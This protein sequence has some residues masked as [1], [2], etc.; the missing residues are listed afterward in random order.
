M[1]VHI[2]GNNDTN[3]SHYHITP[4]HDYSFTCPHGKHTVRIPRDPYSIK[5]RVSYYN[6]SVVDEKN[7]GIDDIPS[8]AIKYF[9]EPP[10]LKLLP[11]DPLIPIEEGFPPHLHP[12]IA[13]PATDITDS[14][15]TA[16]WI[17]SPENTETTLGYYLDVA[18][19][20]AFTT[21]VTGYRN[22]DVGNGLEWTITGLTFSTNYY[23]KLRAYNITLLSGDSNIITVTTG[24]EVPHLDPPVALPATGVSYTHIDAFTANWET[25]TDATGY[26]LYVSVVEDFS[27]YEQYHIPG[28][29]VDSYNLSG[30]EALDNYWYKLTA[31]NATLIS[32]FS[33][34]I[35]VTTT[36]VVT[37]YG[38]LY[39]WYAINGVLLPVSQCAVFFNDSS[40]PTKVY[41]YEP[42]TGSLT[43]RTTLDFPSPDITS[44]L[45]K[46][47]SLGYNSGSIGKF[48]EYDI[49]LDPFT[50]NFNRDII[51]GFADYPGSG[52][53]MK[54]DHTL[55]GSS[56]IGPSWDVE[57]IF[58]YDISN[59][60]VIKTQ[61]FSLNGRFVTGDIIYNSITDTYIIATNTLNNEYITE[62]ASDGTII[63]DI[64]ISLLDTP[65]VVYGLFCYDDFVFAVATDQTDSFIYKITT[66]D[67]SGIELVQTIEGKVVYGASQNLSCISANLPTNKDVY[68]A[69]YNWYAASKN[70]G[71]GVGSI[72]PTG[73]HVPTFDEWLV[74]LEYLGENSA[75]HLK[76][77]GF[78]HWNPPNT[79]ADNSSG[80]TALGSGERFSN[81]IYM[82]IGYGEFLWCVTLHAD[83]T[84][85]S[86]ILYST[87]NEG[88][89]TYNFTKVYGHSIR[90]LANFTTKTHGQTGTVTDVDG[91]VYST[92]C[93][94]SQEWMAENLKTEHFN[95]GD[96][97]PMGGTD[98]TFFTG[99]EWA[100]LTDAGM[101]YYDNSH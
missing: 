77:V 54:D 87:G 46:I 52:L 95:N 15:F 8:R 38:A 76:E 23:Y 80:F 11:C 12:P 27:V 33:N 61:L 86:L 48:V 70:G 29:S 45:T 51:I 83:G 41:S 16:N 98:P 22:V 91:N 93:I 13:L 43:Y 94:G 82:S 6:T 7:P 88:S 5:G 85:Y 21:Y 17:P 56:T 84:C 89:I 73:W 49:T 18:T 2:R 63:T 47:W 65:R 59:S 53:S 78:T 39:N 79:G 55:I 60:P 68:G 19:D 50:I 37:G 1:A 31:Y 20:Y 14:A 69:L 40:D 30:L 10:V 90:C 62:Y 100:A 34:T 25:I 101:C 97:I 4:I 71:T 35:H 44:S 75:G 81:G 92:I 66:N 58:L 9:S 24:V 99:E 42:T 3:T 28:Q 96:D 64:D 26:Y 57:Y 67:I 72:A 36:A 32:V 74:L